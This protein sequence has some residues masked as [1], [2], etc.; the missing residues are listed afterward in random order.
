M[1]FACTY[2]ADLKTHIIEGELRVL[3]D[4]IASSQGDNVT[5]KRYSYLE[6]VAEDGNVTLV[7]KV[8]VPL[9]VD[10]ILSPGSKGAFLVSKS[11]F[12]SSTDLWAARIDDEEAVNEFVAGGTKQYIQ[13]YFFLS[14][15]V[16]VG[17]VLSF[18]LVGIPILLVALWAMIRWPM[19]MKNLR[20]K[21]RQAGFSMNRTKSL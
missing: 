14:L 13:V 20:A 2:E 11:F 18:I 8:N 4:Y 16:I 5:K 19:W 1:S 17:S 10:R 7:K 9:D 3:G 15:M 21:A 12:P 6:F